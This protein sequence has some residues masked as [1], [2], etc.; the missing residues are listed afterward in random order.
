[1]SGAAGEPHRVRQ[2]PRRF[3]TTTGTV[4]RPRS[5][6]RSSRADERLARLSRRG[7]PTLRDRAMRLR[8]IPG[9]SP[10]VSSRATAARR[11]DPGV[12]AAQVCRVEMDER[13]R[14]RSLCTWFPSS[15][16][17]TRPQR[18]TNRRT[19]PRADARLRV[20]RHPPDR[21]ERT[22]GCYFRPDRRAVRRPQAN[23]RLRWLPTSLKIGANVSSASCCPPRPYCGS[24]RATSPRVT[25]PRGMDTDAGA[26]GAEPKDSDDP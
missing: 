20:S 16:A 1:M 9:G 23:R 26:H 10:R 25:H 21:L 13:S 19:S 6:E 7:L 18:S 17:R 3:G 14:R 22:P 24:S 4:L 5:R 15:V 8:P 11:G 12:A 2:P